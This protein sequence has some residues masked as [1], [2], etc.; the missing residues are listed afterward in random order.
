MS[1][2]MLQNYLVTI[3]TSRGLPQNSWQFGNPHICDYLRWKADE[4]WSSSGWD[5]W[6]DMLIFTV[7][8]KKVQLLPSQSRVTGPILITF[9]H[10]VATILPLNILE[11]KLP[12]SLL[13]WNTSLPNEGHFASF[14]QNRLPWQ[15]PLRNW[16]KRS[17]SII[18]KQI[19]IIWC[20]D[21][22][23]RSIGSW[24]NLSPS[25]H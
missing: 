4:G 20:K 5:I 16:K 19:S 22:K 10:D 18:Y 8:S 14:D 12:Y 7:S 6:S 2:K 25:Y 11:L 17:R 21:C 1:A 13:F 9:A 23:N 3:A 24:D 15:R